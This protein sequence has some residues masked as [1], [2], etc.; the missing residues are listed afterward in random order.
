MVLSVFGPPDPVKTYA[1]F[2][3]TLL[4]AIPTGT[5]TISSASTA[6][7]SIVDANQSST[8]TDQVVAIAAYKRGLELVEAVKYTTGAPALPLTK[9]DEILEYVKNNTAPFYHAT[10]TCKMGKAE[11]VG[12]GVVVDSKGGV[13][14]GIK[15]LRIVDASIMP[16]MPPGYIMSTVYAVAEKLADD[17]KGGI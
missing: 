13:L 12:K 17:I 5:V 14:G 6:D 16:F 15:G 8:R 4:T 11:D 1:V 10:G 2:L 3:L 9:D 7:T